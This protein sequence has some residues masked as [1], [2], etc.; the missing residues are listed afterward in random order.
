MKRLNLLVLLLV[1]IFAA[2][3]SSHPNN[4]E[5]PPASELPTPFPSAA[6]AP[7]PA[8]SVMPA[9]A[10]SAQEMG[11]AMSTPAPASSSDMP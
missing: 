9:E 2:G 4:G 3:C 8:Q 11:S 6:T 5:I 7:A 1:A 10:A